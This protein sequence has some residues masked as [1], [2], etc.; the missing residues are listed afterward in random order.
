MSAGRYYQIPNFEFEIFQR[1]WRKVRTPEDSRLVNDQAGRPDG[2]VQQRI[3]S[4][5]HGLTSVKTGRALVKR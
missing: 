2:R 5:K 1:A 4:P 3:D